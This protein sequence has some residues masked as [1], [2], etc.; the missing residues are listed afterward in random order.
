MMPR[1]ARALGLNPSNKKPLPELMLPENDLAVCSLRDAKNKAE[2]PP[3]ANAETVAAAEPSM[4]HADSVSSESSPGPYGGRLDAGEAG[5]I[6][7]E[8]GACVAG[9]IGDGDALGHV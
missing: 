1:S 9:A 5:G 8:G 2:R 3:A 4:S 6:G 7:G